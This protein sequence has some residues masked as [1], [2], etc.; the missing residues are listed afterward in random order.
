M[1]QSFVSKEFLLSA[2]TNMTSFFHD[3]FELWIARAESCHQDLFVRSLSVAKSSFFGV[4]TGPFVV[5]TGPFGIAS[6]YVVG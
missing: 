4:Y 2:Y 1:L 6:I 3:I 5:F